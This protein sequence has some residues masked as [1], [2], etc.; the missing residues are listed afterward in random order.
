MKIAITYD[1]ADITR[2]IRQDL[3]RQG[4]RAA[5]CA[6]RYSKGVAH[7]DVEVQPDDDVAAAPPVV[8]APSIEQ[9]AALPPRNLDVNLERE[10]EREQERERMREREARRQ[11]NLEAI[12]G[13]NNPADFSDVMRASRS[14]E[15]QGGGMFPPSQRQLMDGESFDPP[16]DR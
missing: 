5:D 7:V 3:A 16:G 15:R 13:G 12:E 14:I 4:I 1:N 11:P 8:V 9:A 2:L 6:V 10:Q